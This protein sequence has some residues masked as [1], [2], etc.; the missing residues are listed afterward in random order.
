MKRIR[1]LVLAGAIAA[2]LPFGMTAVGA[3]GSTGSTSSSYVY[4]QDKVDYDFAGTQLDVGFQIRCKDSSGF[5][6]VNVTVKQTY[7]ETFATA[8]SD[9]PNGVVCDGRT[10]S[11]AVTTIGAGFDAGKALV[12][13]ELLTPTNPSGSKKVSKTV[14]VVVVEPPQQRTELGA[15]SGAPS[16]CVGQLSRRSGPGCSSERWSRR[17]GRPA[18]PAPDRGCRRCRSGC[19]RTGATSRPRRRRS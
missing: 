9:G 8:F 12:T 11:V 3:T 17:T 18:G 14:T 1:L 2:A 4:I 5:G 15:P 19:R 16:S 7:P 13:A 6:A 10:R